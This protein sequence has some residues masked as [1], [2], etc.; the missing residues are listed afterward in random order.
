MTPSKRLAELDLTLP[1][2][3]APVGSYVP[4]IRS[5][6]QVFTSGQLPFREGKL[7]CAGKVPTEVSLEDAAHGA[8]I[9]AL[10]GLAA[11]AQVAGGLN[12]ISRIVRVG[13]FVNSS[14]GFAAQPKV[15]NGA[16]DL[17]AK[18]F[19]DAGQHARAA[20]GMA[21]LPMNAAVEVE[22]L[23]EVADS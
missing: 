19:G 23:V 21:G 16:S 18:I 10:N 2:V 17:L 4:A 13:V 6:R 11:A 12:A 20:V 22:L 9:A 5:G 8:A 1:D 3:A 14:P 15:A 7:L